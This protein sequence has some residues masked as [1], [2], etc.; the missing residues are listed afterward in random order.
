[1]PPESSESNYRLVQENLLDKIDLF[2][3]NIHRIRGED[4]PEK[5]AERYSEEINDFTFKRGR[6]PFFNAVLLGLGEDGHTA[7]IFPGS[8]HLF[9]SEKICLSTIHPVTGQHRITLGGKVINNAASIIFHVTGKNKTDIVRSIVDD[10]EP[11]KKYPASYVSPSEGKLF[12]YLDDE[13][14]MH[15]KGR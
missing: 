6:L 2:P 3:M 11:W 5:E 9:R 14:G 13:A 8:E 12:W 15:L 7:S 1:V 4:D 10:T